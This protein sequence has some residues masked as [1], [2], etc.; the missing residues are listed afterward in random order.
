MGRFGIVVSLF[1]FLAFAGASA[2]AKKADKPAP[3][4]KDAPSADAIV[5]H[6]LDSDPWGLGGAE[7]VG[8]VIVT[9]KT[10]TTRELAYTARSRQHDPPLSKAIV[11]FSKPA[12]MKG[13]GF[14]QIQ[15]KGGDDDRW[16]Y[17]PEL[18]RSRRIAGKMRSGAFMSTDFSYADLD[19]ADLRDAKNTL[20]GEDTLGKYEAWKVEVIPQ[21][22]DAVYAKLIVWVRKDNL[23]P[24]KIEMYN[25]AGVLL[26]TQITEEMKKQGGKWLVT[27]TVM[28]NDAEGRQTELTLDSVTPR[29]DI[30]D[31]E[32]SVRNLEKN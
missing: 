19:R 28:K 32:F 20:L 30:D 18:A 9:D 26:K 23:M 22:K 15:K 13:V 24:L 6:V 5:G 17:L 7:V 11:R 29:D 27:K 16:L 2:L 3:P 4:P 31:G 1:G 25:K 21:N 12:D 14:L 10:G 8:H